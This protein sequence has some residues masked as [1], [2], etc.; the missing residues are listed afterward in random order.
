MEPILFN[1]INLL[2]PL[3][4]VLLIGMEVDTD[5]KPPDQAGIDANPDSYKL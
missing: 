1:T 4:Y 5:W 3:S 2:S